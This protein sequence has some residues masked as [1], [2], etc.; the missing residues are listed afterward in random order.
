MVNMELIVWNLQMMFRFSVHI[1]TRS[2]TTCV[3]DI[4]VVI[5]CNKWACPLII[6]V[7]HRSCMLLRPGS[8]GGVWSV[9]RGHS[10]NSHLMVTKFYSCILL[11]TEIFEFVVSQNLLLWKYL[12][13]VK[14]WWIISVYCTRI[15]QQLASKQPFNTLSS[16]DYCHNLA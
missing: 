14:H 1:C 5:L 16:I 10:F 11:I 7:Y 3:S 6:L 2:F 12:F 4:A 15:I 13:F 9:V 8:V